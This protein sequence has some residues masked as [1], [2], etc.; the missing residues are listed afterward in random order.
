MPPP[1][2][3]E[4]LWLIMSGAYVGQELGAELGLVPP[5]M[6]PIGHSRLYQLQI[7]AIGAGGHVHLVLPEDFQLASEDARQLERSG[8]SIVPLPEGFALGTALVYALNFIGA[9]D[10]CVRI[11]LGDTYIGDLPQ[12]PDTIAVATSAD[13]YDWADVDTIDGRITRIHTEAA[14]MAAGN[15][16]VACGFFTLQSSSLLVRSIIRSGGDFIKGLSVYGRH[17]PLRVAHVNEWLDFGHIQTFFQSRRTITTARAFNELAVGPLSVRKSS[18]SNP[19]KIR[20]ELQWLGNAPRQLQVYCSRV[21]DTGE[22]QHGPYYETEYEYMLTLSELY[23]F[24]SISKS[25]WSRVV[26]AC[27]EFLNT[28]AEFTG[29]ATAGPAFRMLMDNTATRL[30]RFA[31]DTG[32]DIDAPTRLNGRALPSLMQIATDLNGRIDRDAER[33]ECVM[34]GDFCFSNIFYNSRARRVRVIDPRGYIEEGKPTIF[35]DSRYDLAKLAHSAIGRY[36]QILAGRY[37]CEGTPGAGITLE[38]EET[39]I[40]AWLTD[41]FSSIR[42]KRSGLADDEVHAIMTGLFLSML[43]LHADRPDRQSVFIANALRL[44]AERA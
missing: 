34:H 16:T 36:D 11:L 21:I 10:R 33:P 18:S 35:G 12:D 14:G 27:A 4:P 1:Q 24:G 38:F 15:R 19:N 39:P 25:V 8:I 17:R 37:R 42:V 40:R 23:L 26:S 32:F 5:A 29:P 6:M 22:A 43:P 13:D 44:Y 3:A 20:A 30:E 7:E 31:R 9:A 28:C 41:A 2:E